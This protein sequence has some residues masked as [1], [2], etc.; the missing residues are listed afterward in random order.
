MKRIFFVEDDLSLING[1]SFAIKKQGYEIDVARTSL[2]AEKLWINGK[3]DLVILDVSLPDGSGYN[4]CKKI[5]KTSKLPIMFLTA[6]DEETNII[7]GLDI[8]G[9]DYIT[10]PFKLAVFLSRINALLRRSDN[11]NQ[12]NTELNS[13]GIKVQLLKRQVYKNEGQLELTASEYKLLCLFMENPNIVLSPGQILSKLWDCYENYIDN[14]SLTVY[15]RRLRTK[16]E[17]N[18]SNPQKIVTV[19]R[20]GYKWNTVDYGVI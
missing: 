8:G 3:Y 7:M 10:K 9:D 12:T 17:D 5:R 14:N 15:I 4:L 19:R 2:E 16:I 13:N 11:F 20:M 1:L 6:A 18:P